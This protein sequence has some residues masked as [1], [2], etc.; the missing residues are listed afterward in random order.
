ME[1]AA[2]IIP[3]L[4]LALLA[5]R[6]NKNRSPLI[7]F[8]LIAGVIGEVVALRA[9]GS[10]TSGR[11]NL[12]VSVAMGVLGFAILIP[13]LPDYITTNIR[14]IPPLWRFIIARIFEVFVLLPSLFSITWGW[15]RWTIIMC[16]ALVLYLT[17]TA[18]GAIVQRKE[19]LEANPQQVRFNVY[20]EDDLVLADDIEH[21]KL[22]A[23]LGISEKAEEALR[24]Q[25]RERKKKRDRRRETRQRRRKGGARNSPPTPLTKSAPASDTSD[26]AESR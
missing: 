19:W 11:A 16:G 8:A 3:V 14:R 1:A 2:Q 20:T 7:F 18:W 22:R 4:V 5:D 21:A 24:D 6:R 13:H 26:A 12:T 25:I 17:F 23:D 9:I 10:G 15:T